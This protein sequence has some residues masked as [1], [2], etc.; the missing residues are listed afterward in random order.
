MTSSIGENWQN[1]YASSTHT[2]NYSSGDNDVRRASAA[3]V[4][5]YRSTT[6]PNQDSAEDP[7]ASVNLQKP[8]D[9]RELPEGPEFTQMSKFD[10]LPSILRHRGATGLSRGVP[11]TV[12]DN[13][14]KELNSMTWDKLSARAEKVAQMIRDKSGLYRGDRV[15]LIYLQSEVIEFAVAILGCFLAGVVAVPISASA[16]FKDI[17]H[18]LSSTQSHLALTTESNIKA[19]QKL[20]TAQ[21]YNW[22][23]GVE[24]WKT[25]EFGSYHPSKKQELPALQVPDLAYIEFQRSPLGELRGV[26]MSHRTILHQMTCLSAMLRSRSIYEQ[27]SEGKKAQKSPHETILCNLDVR[28]SIGLIIG[29]LWTVYSGNS[30]IWIPQQAVAVGG[31]YAHVISKH[32]A[33]IILSDYATLKLVTY[34][35]QSFPHLT[36][37]YSKKTS[38]NFSSINWCLIDALTVDTEFH[39][40]LANRWL[41]PLGNQRAKDVVA[42]MLT[43][44]EHGGMVVSMRD[45]LEGQEKMGCELNREYED[46]HTAT[47]AFDLSEIV[48]DK[49]SLTANKLT[50]V[51]SLASRNNIVDEAKKHIRVGAFGYPLPDATLAIVNPDTCILSAEMVVGEIWIDSPSLSG[52]FWGLARE[53]DAVFHAVCFD[54]DGPIDMEFLRTGLLG[55]IFNGKVYV[56]G[57]YEDRIRQKKDI[58]DGSE[59]SDPS[60]GMG[61]KTLTELRPQAASNGYFY[62]YI[63]HLVHTIVRGVPR[64]FD[65]SGF[66]IY[67]NGEHLTVIVLESTL[68]TAPLS[69]QALIGPVAGSNTI[70]MLSQGSGSS[71]SQAAMNELCERCIDVLRDTH[72]IRIYCVLVTPSSSLPRITRS[73]RAEIGNML[74]KRRFENGTLPAA[75][76]KFDIDSAVR[77]IPSGQDIDGGIWSP[78]ISEIRTQSLDMADK[79]YS[80]VDFREVVIDDRTAAPLTDFRS[81]VQILQW[82]ISH[83]ADE[84]AYATMDNRARE[85][86]GTSWKKLD[87]KVA[88]VASYIKNTVKVKAGDRVILMYTHSE[89]YVIAV[90]ACILLGVVPVPLPPID[91]TRLSEDVTGLLSIVKD[92]QVKAILTNTDAES[93]LKVKAVSHNIKHLAAQKRIIFP[94]H[95]NTGKVKVSTSLSTKNFQ[96]QPLWFT[97]DYTA[98]VWVYWTPDYR[99][100]CIALSHQSIL[101]MCKIQK[102]TCQMSSTKPILAC[103]RS[104]SGL[105]FLHTCFMGV[106]LGA[107]TLLLSPID[108]AQNPVTFFLSLSR[109]K[110]KDT[111]TT[112][113]MLDHACAIMKPKGFSLSETKNLMVA[114]EGRPR[115]DLVKNVRILFSTTGLESTSINFGYSHILNP[116][117]TT[118]SY[119]SLEPI[120]LWLDPIA[121][122]QGFISVVNPENSPNALHLHD[123][124]M[125]PVN[126][127]VA[128]VNPET[129]RLCHVGEYGEIWVYSEGNAL[130]FY[131][132]NDSFDKERMT[133]KIADGNSDIEYVRTGD[134]G[135]LQTV[136]RNDSGQSIE[137]QTLFVLGSIGETFEVL[138]L[139]HFPMDIE[140]KIEQS[141]TAIRPGGSAIFQAGGMIIV[142]I[143]LSRAVPGANMASMTPVIVNKV[144]QEHQF[145][146]DIVAFVSK[147]NFPRSRL[148][149]KQR[150][151]LLKLWVT[152]KLSTL[153]VF[154]VSHGEKSL[155]KAVN[156]N[157]L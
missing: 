90:H 44:S 74:C 81:I 136:V 71:T 151:K 39:D 115:T 104:L 87:Q 145:V 16:P 17:E 107:S 31:L 69:L 38:V 7:G 21:R 122:R 67:V 144:I 47:E 59:D 9:P 63:S 111:Y 66:D 65:A 89:E 134:L 94:S 68:A 45:W 12:L 96:M 36:R 129:C 139:N 152:N 42:P 3:G 108:Y 37:N 56:L 22:P 156:H 132:S 98:L 54:K 123:S 86:K 14:G 73:G 133:G 4:Q 11:I 83:Q 82:R 126:T 78:A 50:V 1:Q 32:R 76:V 119:M 35:Y 84:L 72:Q 97:K 150:G 52:G 142:V 41:K 79:Q 23:R 77:N 24:W 157:E 8:L 137:L 43:L 140:H 75:F 85:G 18:V 112:P 80:G 120:D 102:E 141:L 117:V 13:K 64:V 55:F 10:N 33:T 70:S 135:F 128:I 95:Y 29:I 49:S 116:M 146:I 149:E 148:G 58:I 109:Y 48:L 91:N 6:I 131:N 143:E 57:L 88:S 28:Q 153:G 40:V 30:M 34:N 99:P 27:K 124:G 93:I 127:Q 19:F 154:G 101:G 110:V 106:Y 155:I 61:E 92:C 130:G 25:N 138:G 26:V 121:L 46:E 147:E 5:T 2:G 118:R 15:T 60:L 113:Q 20:V 100:Q 103:V 62:Y 125:V 51:T 53:T 105:G 114:C